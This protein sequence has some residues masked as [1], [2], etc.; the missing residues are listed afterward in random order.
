[1]YDFLIKNKLLFKKEEVGIQYERDIDDVELL[2]E[3][4]GLQSAKATGEKS[5]DRT[6]EEVKNYNRNKK[7][8][9]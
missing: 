4:F 8:S 7:Y 1:M 2:K 5:F 3:Y 6:L 9:M